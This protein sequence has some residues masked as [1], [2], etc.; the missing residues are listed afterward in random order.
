MTRLALIS[1]VVGAAVIALRLPGILWPAKYRAFAVQFPRSVLWGR[2]L[3]GIAAAIV[4]VVMFR[5]AND[6]DEWRWAK[7]LVVVGVPVAYGMVYYFGVHYLALRATAALMLLISK[8]MVDAADL[9]E[10]P[11]R[12][13]V[14]VLGYLWVV[15]AIWMT[16]APHHFRDLIGWATADDRRCRYLSSWCVVLGAV[17]VVLGLFAY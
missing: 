6:S 8:V 17:L 13:V 7:P 5:A 4:W 3:I 9:S 11:L 16:I 14:T 2:I 15:A 10:T 1:T 12:L